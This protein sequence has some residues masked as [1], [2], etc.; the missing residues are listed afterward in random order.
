MPLEIREWDCPNCG[1]HHD[2]DGNASVNIRAE[3][4]RQIQ[5]SGTGTSASRG[6][7]RP[8]GGRK[9]VLRQSPIE[10]FGSQ[11]SSKPTP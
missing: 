7:V 10:N 2:R 9:S 4:I 8:K 5:V 1:T 3:G 11:G 6:D